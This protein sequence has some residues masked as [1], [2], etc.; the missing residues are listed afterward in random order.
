MVKKWCF[1]LDLTV[2]QKTIMSSKEKNKAFRKKGNKSWKGIWAANN[3]DV[4]N[5]QKDNYNDE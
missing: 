1:I 3:G 5:K 4:G 2:H